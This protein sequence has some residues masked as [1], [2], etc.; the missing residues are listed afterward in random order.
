MIEATTN[1]ERIDCIILQLGLVGTILSGSNY[2]F[3]KFFIYHL[4]HHMNINVGHIAH[5]NDALFPHH[6]SIFLLSH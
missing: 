1:A 2:T 4:T 3:S 6:F 5:D